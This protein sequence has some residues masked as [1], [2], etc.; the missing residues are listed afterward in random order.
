MNLNQKTNVQADKLGIF[1][2]IFMNFLFSN[3]H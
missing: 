3:G 2:M 1:L